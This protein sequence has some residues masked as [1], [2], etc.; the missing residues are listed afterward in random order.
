MS[1]FAEESTLLARIEI[2][3][4]DPVRFDAQKRKMACA[5]YV[6]RPSLADNSVADF[7]IS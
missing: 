3:A 4:N 1:Q 6:N 5:V 7:L 2:V